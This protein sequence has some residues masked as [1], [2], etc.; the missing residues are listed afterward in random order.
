MV[1]EEVAAV[2]LSEIQHDLDRIFE[3]WRLQTSTEQHSDLTFLDDLL[4]ELD[5]LEPDSTAVTAEMVD[6]L[7][8]R[9]EILMDEIDISLGIEP[10]SI[11]GY[12]DTDSDTDADPAY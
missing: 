5:D 6:E 4:G 9:I 12:S 10:P 8:G 11:T 7:R 2:T 3:R 1:S